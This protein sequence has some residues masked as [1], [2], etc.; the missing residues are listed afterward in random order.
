MISF[1]NSGEL[2]FHGTGLV[3]QNKHLVQ[4]PGAVAR[5][6]QLH[7]SRLCTLGEVC[8]H[9][10]EWDAP[11]SCYVRCL[12]RV[13][14][15]SPGD[16]EGFRSRVTL[17]SKCLR[18]CGQDQGKAIGAELLPGAQE[19]STTWVRASSF[20]NL[21]KSSRQSW[22][23]RQRRSCC[24]SALGESKAPLRSLSHQ[25]PHRPRRKPLQTASSELQ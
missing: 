16:K 4:A 2:I 20:E 1:I 22:H 3:I 14:T 9:C 13:L 10:C 8:S 11:A 25:C 24:P 7:S 5:E 19:S 21:R 17:T 15:G 12:V 18:R 23:I 6:T